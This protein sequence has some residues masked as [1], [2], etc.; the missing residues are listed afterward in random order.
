MRLIGVASTVF[1]IVLTFVISGLGQAPTAEKQFDGPRGD[2]NQRHQNN[3]QGKHRE[4]QAIFRYDTFGDEQLWTNVLRMHEPI[5]TVDP[6]TA[7][8]VGLKVDV[9]ALPTEIIAALRAGQVDLTNPAVT[10]ELLRL[11]A[12][13]GVKGSVDE[14]GQLTSIGVT[15]A[16]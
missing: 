16:L 4:G 11:D 2:G 6:T 1:M 12:V 13:V 3:G 14:S 10:K 15:C 5:A 8:G 9:E 7:L